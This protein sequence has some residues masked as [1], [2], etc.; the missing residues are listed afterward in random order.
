[1]FLTLYLG[2][3]IYFCG[4]PEYRTYKTFF[5][6]CGF[7]LVAMTSQRLMYYTPW[8]FTDAGLIACGLAYEKT[9]T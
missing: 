3:S 4:S 6:R 8:C 7:F 2:F 9:D 1:M 5:H